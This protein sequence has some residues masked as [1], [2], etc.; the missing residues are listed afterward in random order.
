MEKSENQNLE[1]EWTR[2]L[3]E[4]KEIGLTPEQVRVFLTSKRN[5]TKV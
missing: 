3:E 4:A 1:A 2:L 5:L